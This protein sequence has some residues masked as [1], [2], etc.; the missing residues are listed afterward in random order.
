[1]ERRLEG[2][3]AI[4]TG[5]SRMRGIGVAICRE[6]ATLGANLFLTGWPAYDEAENDEA[7]QLGQLINDLRGSGSEIEWMPLD[8]NLP[9]SPTVAE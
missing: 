6:L 4:V 5:V 2:E 8:L 3:V 7:D 1:V 9:E